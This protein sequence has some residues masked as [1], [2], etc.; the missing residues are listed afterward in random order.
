MKIKLGI[1]IILLFVLALVLITSDKNKQKSNNGTSTQTNENQ[2]L[3]TVAWIPF[4]DEPRALASYRNHV[5]KFTFLSVF[6]YKLDTNGNVSLYNQA[7]EDK[8][9]IQFA[10]Q[11]NNKVLAIVANMADYNEGGGWDANRVQN[12]IGTEEARQKHIGELMYLV[13]TR[14]FDGIDIDYEALYPS[15]RNDFSLFIKELANALHKKGKILGIAIQPVTAANS[16]QDNNGSQAEDLPTLAKYADHLDFM[17]YLEHTSS[18]PMGPPGG[19]DWIKQVMSYAINT[20]KIPKNKI[21]M[22]VGLMGISWKENSDGSFTGEKDD[23]P[24]QDIE[25]ITQNNTVIS[26]WNG[27]SQSPYL[28]YTD[29][30][31]KHVVWYED[32]NSFVERIQLAKQLGVKGVGL[33]RLGGEDPRIWNDF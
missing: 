12:V 14:N 33:W 23:I 21:I 2:Q 32:S 9:V 19:L 1:L 5:N 26:E 6:W 13:E 18:D 7:V 22:G 10:H 16:S 31:G 15:Q 4:W 11:H 27:T 30:S 3:T 17:T 29:S 20:L 24:F 28:S 8:S 25:S